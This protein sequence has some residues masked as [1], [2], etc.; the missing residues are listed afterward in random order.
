MDSH[1]HTGGC[2][3]GAV[4][5]RVTARLRPVVLCHCGQ[6]RRWTG[7]MVAATAA[8]LDRFHIESSANLV[9]YRAST[10]ARRGFCRVCGSSLFWQGD[11][12]DYVAILAGTLDGPTGLTI[13]QQIYC[14]DR[15][16]YYPLDPAIPAHDREGPRV[17]IPA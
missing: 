5:Y 16:D 7:H 1:T 8:K 12:G 15:G 4:R 6:C 13:A 9:W 14:L 2:L 11:A 3:C 17:T 10:V